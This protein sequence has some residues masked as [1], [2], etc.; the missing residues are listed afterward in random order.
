MEIEAHFIKSADFKTVQI[1]GVWGGVM[2]NGML[3]VNLFTERVPIPQKII[4]DIDPVTQVAREKH[5]D[6]KTGIVRE[7]Q[8]GVLMDYPTA[9]SFYEFFGNWIKEQELMIH[10]RKNTDAN[11]ATS[12]S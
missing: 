4:F 11:D 6:G 3:N 10:G 9:K 12:K 1:T 8:M 2:G 7:V 5:K